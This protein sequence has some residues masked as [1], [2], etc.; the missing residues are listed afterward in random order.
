MWCVHNI[1]CDGRP[2]PQHPQHQNVW[3]AV[4]SHFVPSF[5]LF[6]HPG[7]PGLMCLSMHE[8]NY[9]YYDYSRLLNWTQVG[10]IRNGVNLHPM[11]VLLD[12]IFHFCPPMG[13]IKTMVFHLSTSW[14]LLGP[15]FSVFP[16]NSQAGSTV[17]KHV[18]YY[19]D[20]VFSFKHPI[21][22][23]FCLSHM[24]VLLRPWFPKKHS[25]RCYSTHVF[26]SAG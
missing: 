5:Y 7:H 19:W 23:V 24:W 8:R 18:W 3:W 22:M 9:Y 15:W 12:V 21:C 11:V 14:V 4:C 13:T 17:Q 6:T 1:V 2:W 10:I 20:H 25:N 26:N 16:E